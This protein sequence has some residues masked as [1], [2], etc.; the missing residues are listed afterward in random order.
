M[1]I[2]LVIAHRGDSSNALE[3]SLE[4]VR[5]ALSLPVDMIEVDIR[6]SRD[7]VLYVM[8]DKSTGRTAKENIDI[9]RATSAMIAGIRLT[10]G[11]PIPTLTDVVKAVAGHTGLNLELKSDG[12]GLAA[13]EYFASAP[14][15]GYVLLSS[16][17]EEEVFAVRR[18][19]PT[20]RTALCR[21][22]FTVQDVPAY[23]EQGYTILSL[24][25][26]AV[27]EKLIAACHE[28]EIDVYVWTVDQEDE[29]RKFISWGVNGIYS[30]KPAALKELLRSAEFGMR[31]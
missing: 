15:R 28:Q 26:N 11:E 29:M 1:P 16:F 10:N 9:E 6:K 13:A 30:N 20:M 23:K 27:N 25:K 5:R 21:E 22:V 12:A 17:K 14:Y 3:N 8:H 7:N 19:M 4:A 24:K 2:P 18:A 31:S